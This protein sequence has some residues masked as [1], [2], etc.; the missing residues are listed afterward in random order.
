MFSANG[1]KKYSRWDILFNIAAG[2]SATYDLNHSQVLVLHVE[3]FRLDLSKSN[4]EECFRNCLT[5]ITCQ[6]NFLN[7][8]KLAALENN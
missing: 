8:N 1:H 5:N 7:Q 2:I 6:S 4:L 3:N